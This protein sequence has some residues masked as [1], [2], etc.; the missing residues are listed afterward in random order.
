M[1]ARKPA[2]SFIF[3]TLTLDIL[4]IGLIVPILPKLIEQYEGGNV[5]AA[6]STYGLLYALYALMQFLFAPLI[7]SLSD[8]FGRRPV[9]LI[10][11]LGSALDYFVIA[12]APNLAWF[13]LGRV[14][15][16]LTGANF[17]AASAY[18]ADIS[19][20]EKRAANFGMIGAAF[21]LGFV[22][23]PVLGGLLGQYGMKVPFFAA[24]G[25]TLLNW[26][27]GV[28]VLPESLAPENR[29]DFSWARSNPIGSLLALRRFPTLLG[30]I[31]AYFIAL[32]AHQV[33]PSIWVLYT[34]YR[35]GWDTLATG[36]SL[37][38]V[39]VMAGGVQGGLTKR[40]VGAFGEA[41]TVRYG[42]IMAT[43]FYAAYGLA[44]QPWMIY[45][46]IVFG[47]LSGLVTPAVQA[48]MSQAVPADE[49]GALQ[50]SLTSLSSLTGIIGPIVCT[51]L[52]SFFV[53]EKAPIVLPGAPFF[54]SASLMLVALAFALPAL[55]RITPR[56]G[57]AHGSS[58][59]P[60]SH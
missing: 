12:F 50:G 53:S 22:I 7:G 5:A 47:S 27:Y 28:F 41:K 9:I 31:A 8:R 21:G 19:P 24:G 46:C 55:R 3:I 2:L 42:L 11:L 29:R 34:S 14:I 40:V 58:P 57:S 43:F 35:F 36:L 16:G 10:S 60:S 45:V 59:V 30:L 18:I 1:S 20:P 6:S 51:H 15:A 44:S 49:Q 37:A 38:A 56:S 26:V 33:Y 48:L 13:A 39:G 54:W 52:F 4:G 32:L 25:L 23:G 17:A